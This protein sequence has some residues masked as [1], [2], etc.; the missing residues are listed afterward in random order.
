MKGIIYKYKR[1][2]LTLSIVICIAMLLPTFAQR[3]TYIH[4]DICGYDLIDIIVPNSII[5]KTLV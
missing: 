4:K 2:L 1:I 3:R 5:V